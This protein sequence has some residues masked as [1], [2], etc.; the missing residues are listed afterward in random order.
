[1]KYSQLVSEKLSSKHMF[2][3]YGIFTVFTV[4]CPK[5]WT[6][7]VLEWFFPIRTLS[8]EAPLHH[9]VTLTILTGDLP[10]NIPCQNE[11]S[12]KYKSLSVWNMLA[13]VLKTTLPQNIYSFKSGQPSLDSKGARLS[14]FDKYIFAT[15]RIWLW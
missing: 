3:Y 12:Y 5:Y 13:S 1:M 4:F 9:S 8:W 15:I 2:K 14:Q 11:V 6:C 10:T 7:G